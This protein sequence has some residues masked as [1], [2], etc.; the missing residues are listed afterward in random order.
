MEMVIRGTIKIVE[1]CVQQGLPEPDFV[2]E[3]GVM[4]VVF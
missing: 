3:S 2:E 1:N 4:K